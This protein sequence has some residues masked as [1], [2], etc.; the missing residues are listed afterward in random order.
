MTRISPIISVI[1][2]VYNSEKYLQQAIESLIDQSFGDWEL[3]CVNDGSTDK[4]LTILLN[5]ESK[6]ARIKV[7]DR[8]KN[9]GSAAAARNVALKICRGKFL[10]FLD[11]DDVL[12]KDCLEMSY[13]KIISTNADIIIPDLCFFSDEIRKTLP[14]DIIGYFGDREILL[15]SIQAFKAS[16]EWKISGLGL[17]RMEIVKK[18]GF[19]ETEFNGDEY[20]TRL[21]FLNSNKIGFSQGKYYYRQHLQSATKMQSPKLFDILVTD[22][23]ILALAEEYQTGEETVLIC[24]EKIVD[25]IIALKILLA[26]SKV[27]SIIK[28]KKELQSLIKTYYLKV[29]SSY[30]MFNGNYFQY[31]RNRLIFMNFAF[32]RLYTFFNVNVIPFIKN[33]VIFWKNRKYVTIW[34]CY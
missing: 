16:L 30:I 31:I 12:S 33:M 10:H 8:I 28:R 9:N 2:P 29:D 7:V 18:F 11:S 27:D 21:L 3:I 13:N 5:Y 4:S 1:M 17:Y 23:K 20:S 22:Y 19:V 24:K 25:S 26:K 6:D 14:H 34:F 32:F 15:N